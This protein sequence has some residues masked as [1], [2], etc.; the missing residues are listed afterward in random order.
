MIDCYLILYYQQI[1]YVTAIISYYL[2]N[3]FSKIYIY[4]ISII[5]AININKHI[6]SILSNNKK[7][8]FKYFKLEIS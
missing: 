7:V 1:Y 3:F 2:A 8:Q 5:I 4:V 6:Y